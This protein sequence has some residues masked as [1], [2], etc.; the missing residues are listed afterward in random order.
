MIYAF[1]LTPFTYVKF[2]HK[3]I[4][5]LV[6][7]ELCI[8]TLNQ[9]KRPTITPKPSTS[10]QSQPQ[11]TGISCNHP[12]HV[13]TTQNQPQSPKINHYQ[14]KLNQTNQP[15]QSERIHPKPCKASYN[16]PKSVTTTPDLAQAGKTTHN[17]LTFCTKVYHS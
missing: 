1:W 16:Y 4:D 7:V 5:F 11:T 3:Y 9:L 2:W 14:P 8:A 13:T 12:K 10:M 17:H 6:I 15:N